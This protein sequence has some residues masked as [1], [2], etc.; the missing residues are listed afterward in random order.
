MPETYVF[1]LNDLVTHLELELPERATQ[2]KKGE[3]LCLH[4]VP[5]SAIV[6]SA[7]PCEV[8]ED[9][10]DWKWQE[11]Y[12]PLDDYSGSDLEAAEDNL[13]DDIIKM[14]EGDWD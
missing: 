9:V 1:S 3:Y 6:N 11:T 10:E 14:I 13:N 8:K 7:S 4:T 2:H 12:H 5:T